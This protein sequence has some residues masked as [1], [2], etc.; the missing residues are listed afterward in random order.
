MAEVIQSLLAGG[1]QALRLYN[2]QFGRRMEIGCQWGKIRVI[3]R[4]TTQATSNLN[5]CGLVLG[6]S[7]GTTDMFRSGN[8]TDFIGGHLGSA[9]QATTW[10]YNSGPPAFA[11]VGGFS[12]LA[13]RRI[14]ATNTTVAPGGSTTSYQPV[15]P[16]RGIFGVDIE[17]A[18]SVMKVRPLAVGTQALAQTDYNFGNMMFNT[19]NDLA[20]TGLI[21]SSPN[22]IN[23]PYTGNYAFDSV[24]IDW[25][26]G[27]QPIEISDI[28]V[29]R[30]F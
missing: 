20:T 5:S 29:V 10:T 9:L 13:V 8:T 30:F 27:I 15:S 16:S 21:G 14:G 19:D 3:L 4:F 22:F 25:N 6:V 17:K 18:N 12:T 11:S 24:N 1:G 23:V 26:N 28:L 7:Q 2:E